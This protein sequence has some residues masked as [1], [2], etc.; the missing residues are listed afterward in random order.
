VPGDLK[1]HETE[2]DWTGRDEISIQQLRGNSSAR[3]EEGGEILQQRDG[4]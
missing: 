4:F 1:E 2:K 3:L